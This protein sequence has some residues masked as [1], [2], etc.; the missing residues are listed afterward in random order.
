MN[1]SLFSQVQHSRG[2]Q[3]TQD[4]ALGH[5][6]AR[7]SPL[8]ETVQARAERTPARQVRGLSYSCTRMVNKAGPRLRDPAS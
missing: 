2:V 7:L 6:H 4:E 8:R 1:P 5:L 3:G